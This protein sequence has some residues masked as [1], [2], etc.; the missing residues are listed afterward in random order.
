MMLEMLQQENCL[1]IPFLYFSLSY[2]FIVFI[3]NLELS[4]P[5][6]ALTLKPFINMSPGTSVLASLLIFFDLAV[7]SFTAS[8]LPCS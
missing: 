3:F 8:L 1:K 7:I 6:I 2:F 5:E 4:L